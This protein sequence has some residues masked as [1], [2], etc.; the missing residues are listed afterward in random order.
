MRR[1]KEH[2]VGLDLEGV[3][4]GP[5]SIL[6]RRLGGLEERGYLLRVFLWKFCPGA[7]PNSTVRELE[8]PNRWLAGEAA[9]GNAY[10]P[11]PLSLLRSLL[12]SSEA[13]LMSVPQ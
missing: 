2:E 8:T 4:W 11:I 12:I 13:Q 3:C 9:K 7:R 10:L 1:V 6:W 5:W